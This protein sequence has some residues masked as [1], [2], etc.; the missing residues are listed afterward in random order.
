MTLPDDI[1]L[2]QPPRVLGV[3]Y[4][5]LIALW[6]QLPSP[7]PEELAG[8]YAGYDYLGHSQESFLSSYARLERGGGAWWLGKA[9]SN[10]PGEGYNRLLTPEGRTVRRDRFSVARGTSA[11][12][13]RP[14]LVLAYRD[15][16]NAPGSV[17]L[18]DDLRR[19][20][21]GLY[22]AVATANAPGGGRTAPEP[23]VI[24]GPPNGW[25]GVDDPDLELT[26]A[27]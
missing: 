17:D 26:H 18:V 19:V 4:D 6:H 23:F 24:A 22:L 20:R 2:W 8:E 27:P 9:F 11:I 13:G 1:E 14:A 12:D 5:D 16:D 3:R 10:V 21:A 15:F 25:V 7:A